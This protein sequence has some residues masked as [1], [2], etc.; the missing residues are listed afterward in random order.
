MI[1][2]ML[3]GQSREQN[4]EIAD[5]VQLMKSIDVDKTEEGEFDP[6]KGLIDPAQLVKTAK[7]NKREEEKVR[8]TCEVM[9]V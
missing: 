7:S 3:H 6:T 4:L 2:H 8:I 9:S 1:D 5:L